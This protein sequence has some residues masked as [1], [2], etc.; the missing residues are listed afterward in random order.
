MYRKLLTC[1]KSIINRCTASAGSLAIKS[2]A[3]TVPSK[4]QS[5]IDRETHF[6]A[7]NYHPIPVAIQRGSGM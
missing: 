5:I 1:S 2:N 3:K 6:G 4:T 7:S